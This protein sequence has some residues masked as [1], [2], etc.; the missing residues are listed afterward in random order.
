MLRIHLKE[1]KDKRGGNK[2]M[3]TLVTGGSGSGKSEFAEN[4]VLSYGD[5]SNPRYY[6]A[7]MIP[8]DEECKRKIKRHQK[9]REQKQFQTIECFTDLQ[10]VVVD[11]DSIVLLE[12]MSNLVAN[13][14]YQEDG[15][16]ENT[17]S[18]ILEGVRELVKQAKH[19]IVV[20][21]EVCSDGIVYDEETTK[22]MKYL[23]QINTE[24]GKI[25]NQVIEVVY[26][27]PIYQKGEIICSHLLL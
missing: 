19:V 7:T 9:M 20:S 12:C 11:S 17:I 18:A 15:A 16:K 22:Y 3:L 8:F 2:R 13:E 5:N 4:L 10:K 1:K 21:N 14:I 23:A 26:T 6:I 24:I 27:I 25:A